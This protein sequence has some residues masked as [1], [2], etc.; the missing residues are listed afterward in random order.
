VKVFREPI[1]EVKPVP[2]LD[3]VEVAGRALWPS[4]TRLPEVGIPAVD[5]VTRLGLACLPPGENGDLSP[6]AR[7]L[8]WLALGG[9]PQPLLVRSGDAP[10]G[11]ISGSA[12]G[13]TWKETGPRSVWSVTLSDGKATE[14]RRLASEPRVL[15]DLHL[16]LTGAA[17]ESDLASRILAAMEEAGV[18][19]LDIVRVTIDVTPAAPLL[20]P[21]D[22]SRFEGKAVSV[23]VNPKL[24][25][26]PWA[27][28]DVRSV[29]GRFTA[30]LLGRL[31]QANEPAARDLLEATL[32]LG[33]SALAGRPLS[34]ST[35][36][37][38]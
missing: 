27:E 2:G 3:G 21:V 15:H 20:P 14:V 26:A 12:S 36:D 16:K 4:D 19:A 28:P 34:V 11:A 17:G 9:R 35:G 38:E 32:F 31:R 37:V 8:S 29:E 23:V 7:G 22:H 30:D 10:A 5:G 13:R 1:W 24:A 33:R 25:P 6:V 18:R